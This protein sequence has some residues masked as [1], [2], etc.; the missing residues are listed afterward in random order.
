MEEKHF[1]GAMLDAADGNLDPAGTTHAYA[2]S[3]RIAGAEIYLQ[4][5]VT[6]LKPRPDGSWDVITDKGSIQAEHVVNCGGLWAREIGRMVGLELPVLAMEHM[7]LVTD[8]MPEVVAFNKERGHELP[9][10]ID[11]KAEIYMR[12]ERSGMVLGTYEKACVPWQPRETPWEFRHRA[13]AARSRPHRAVARARLQAFPRHGQGRHQ[14]DHQ[15]ALHLLARR[16]SAGRPGP[17]PEELLVRLR[18]HGGLQPGRRRRPRAVAMDGQRRSGLRRL[19]HG[20]RPLRRMGDPQL[21]QREGARELFPPLLDPLPQRGAAG[22]PPAADHLALRHDDRPGRGH[23][24]QLGPGDAALVRAQG[25]RAQG[26]RLLPPLQRFRPCEGGSAWA[27]ATA[28]ASPRS[29]TSP[30]TNSPA[31]APR[32]SSRG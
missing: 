3:A 26:H 18:G 32:P 23:G 9:H 1:V 6:E 31:R 14:A 20:H 27:C 4:T 13:A 24:R 29:P 11:F 25:R 5:R 7:Y 2:K 15:R 12:Q 8:E 16:Q 10:A 19:G 22:G 21:H 17:G 28:S 30:S